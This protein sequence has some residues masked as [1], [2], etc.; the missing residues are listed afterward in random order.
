[1]LGQ[2]L[3][4]RGAHMRTVRQLLDNKPA[5]IHAVSA[6]TSVI[7]AIRMMAR[8]RIGAVLV[9]EGARLLGIVS[10]RDYARKVVLEGRSS[11]ETP[12]R[13]IM[14]SE[15]VTVGPA[16]NVAACMEIV[17]TRR[18]RHLPVVEDGKVIG[19]VSIGDLVAAVIDEQRAELEQL[20]RYI[21]TG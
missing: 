21:T 8:E 17:T 13:T 18:I 1:M 4:N 5:V 12:V 2:T 19:L 6:E 11:R 14:T 15:V 9:M 10:E 16:Q 20:Q 3:N 7:E